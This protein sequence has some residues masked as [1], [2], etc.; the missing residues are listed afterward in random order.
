MTW[1]FLA[2]ARLRLLDM[3]RFVSRRKDRK[4]ELSRP[5]R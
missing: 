3:A 2:P 5:V 1:T 4:Q